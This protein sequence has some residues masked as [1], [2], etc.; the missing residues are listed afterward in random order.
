MNTPINSSIEQEQKELQSKKDQIKENNVEESKEDRNWKIFREERER[1]R[2]AFLEEKKRREE[3]EKQAALLKEA[4]ETLAKPVKESE[5]IDEEDSKL[6][7][8]VDDAFSKYERARQEQ[9][10]KRAAEELPYRLEQ[11]CPNFNEVC[12]D[13]NVDYL[14]YQH[15]HIYNIIKS[16]PDSL[17]KWKNVY[18]TIKKLVPNAEKKFDEKKMESNLNKP[19]SLSTPG[20]AAT[21]DTPPK[22]IDEKRRLENWMRMQKVMRGG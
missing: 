1:E 15:P 21:N 2:K 18:H 20:V 7:K 10:R 12:R 14:Q 19:K 4:I 5:E 13:E 11:E 6:R 9:E 17:D 22:I 16:T 8:Y 3:A